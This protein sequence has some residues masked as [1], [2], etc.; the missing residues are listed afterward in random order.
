MKRILKAHST[1]RKGD[2]PSLKPLRKGNLPAV[3]TW[4]HN[5]YMG[6]KEA[7]KRFSEPPAMGDSK[8]TPIS[9]A[10]PGTD[11]WLIEFCKEQNIKLTGLDKKD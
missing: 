4:I 3:A 2:Q 1:K 8:A 7:S 9:G 5:V 11:E 10:Q 6:K